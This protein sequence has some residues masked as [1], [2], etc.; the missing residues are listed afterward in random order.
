[1]MCHMAR[2]LQPQLNRRRL[3]AR[4]VIRLCNKGMT[5]Q[6]VAMQY[7]TSIVKII[8]IKAEPRRK[9]FRQNAGPGGPAGP[10]GDAHY[11]RMN[12]ASVFCTPMMSAPRLNSRWIG[13][14]LPEM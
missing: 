6:G 1:M 13:W 5:E 10:F 8:F 14:G 4:Q 9:G 12:C 2:L 11:L 7:Y 3:N